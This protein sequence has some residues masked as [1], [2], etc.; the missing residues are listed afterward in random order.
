MTPATTLTEEYATVKKIKD[1][2]NVSKPNWRIMVDEK[3]NL[4]FSDVFQ[5]KNGMVEPTCEQLNKWK[6]ARR[7]VKFIRLDNAG[8]N[9]LLKPRA[10]TWTG[11]SIFSSNL[12]R[13]TRHSRTIAQNWD[14][15]C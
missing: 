2:P 10:E 13:E 4:K 7:P 12:P 5:T 9:K 1:G 11:S 3:T 8:E 15:P 14:L 6:Q